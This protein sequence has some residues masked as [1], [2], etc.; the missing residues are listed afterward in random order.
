MTHYLD[1]KE[2]EFSKLVSIIVVTYNSANYVLETL[3]ST[4][5]QTYKNIELVITDDCSKDDTI[6]ICSKWIEKNKDRFV[7]TRI[8]QA[9]LNTGIPANCNRGITNSKGK[10]V[11]FIAGDD[12]L[13]EN[14][15]SDCL[16][17]VSKKNISILVGN[18]QPFSISETKKFITHPKYP[19]D[20]GFFDLSSVDQNKYL[21]K[22]S[23][24][25][26]PAVFI[27]RSVIEQSGGFNE[28]Y[29]Y[30]EDLPMWLK[31]T[32]LGY[33]IDFFNK[34]LVYY[35]INHNSMVHRESSYFN[36]LFMKCMLS[37]KKEEV[38][39]K[40]KFYDFL[41]FQSELVFWMVYYIITI[42]FENEKNRTTNKISELS[43]YLIL[44]N[45]V[46]KIKSLLT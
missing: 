9:K 30:F 28:K 2:D 44:D 46:K 5:M 24:N 38:Y 12:L 8:I 36:P 37:F 27:K 22:K 14:C 3:E 17:L 34:T 45:Y 33:R 20:L 25:F 10:W 31:L 16:N 21:L 19:M 6:E 32:G 43:F 7:N 11:K 41:Y 4:K 15:I 26:A 29:K 39:P 42:V 1:E 23:F 35:R 13:M 18:M 40:I